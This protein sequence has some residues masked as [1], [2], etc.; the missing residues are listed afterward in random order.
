MSANDQ[1]HLKIFAASAG[2]HLAK[3]MCGHLDMS[4]GK[5]RAIHFPDGEIIVKLE[6]DV[7]GRDVLPAGQPRREQRVV[8]MGDG[9]GLGLGVE[10][11]ARHD[12]VRLEPPSR[13]H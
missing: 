9:A 5:G 1:E 13:R 11:L 8:R 4:L 12:V 3:E 7:R 10:Q 2:E 6:D